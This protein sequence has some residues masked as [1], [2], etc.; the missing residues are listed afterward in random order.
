M[1]SGESNRGRDKIPR[2]LG[3][4]VDGLGSC[5][6][7][8]EWLG[9]ATTCSGEAGRGGGAVRR[10]DDVLRRRLPR[11]G[12]AP[13][14]SGEVEPPP[15]ALGGAMTMAGCDGGSSRVADPAVPLSVGAYPLSSAPGGLTMTAGARRRRILMV[16]DPVTLSSG[17]RIC[18]RWPPA[19]VDACKDDDS[20]LGS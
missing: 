9:A 8:R 20:A 16:A 3:M 15:S 6:C 7:G 18:H 2:G 14:G 17:G 19:L 13:P 4:A 11:A 12:V 5:R 10:G 1:G